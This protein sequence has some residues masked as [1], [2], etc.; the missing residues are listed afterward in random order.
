M[1]TCNYCGKQLE[2]WDEKCDCTRERTQEEVESEQD[3]G[4]R[5][6]FHQVVR[7]T[8][9]GEPIPWA[10]ALLDFEPLTEQQIKRTNELFAMHQADEQASY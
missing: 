7:D 10:C 5:Q 1:W 6:Q 8:L 3:M 9:G 2:I 4:Y